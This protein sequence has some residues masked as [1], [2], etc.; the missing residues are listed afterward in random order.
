MIF[1]STIVMDL[2]YKIYSSNYLTLF[3]YLILSFATKHQL[4]NYGYFKFK[5]GWSLQFAMKALNL[6]KVAI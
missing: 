2:Q 1:K 5:V 3:N 6:Q 4:S